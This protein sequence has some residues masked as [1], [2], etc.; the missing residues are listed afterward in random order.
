MDVFKLVITLSLAMTTRSMECSGDNNNNNTWTN[1]IYI[2]WLNNISESIKAVRV[3]VTQL[4]NGQTQLNC[5]WSDGYPS[6]AISVGW[7]GHVTNQ[8]HLNLTLGEEEDLNFKCVVNHTLLNQTLVKTVKFFTDKNDHHESLDRLTD[9]VFKMCIVGA[10]MGG[11]M[12]F[13]VVIIV[14]TKCC[15]K[16]NKKFEKVKQNEGPNI[17]YH[18]TTMSLPY[19]V[20]V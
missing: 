19:I 6:N 11:I 5:S 13:I 9:I 4:A 2:C 15:F 17:I 20:T 12:G 1:D 14:C 8:S 16:I 7:M 10:C 18:K 3:N